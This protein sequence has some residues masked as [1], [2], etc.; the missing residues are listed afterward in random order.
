[1]LGTDTLWAKPNP[2]YDTALAALGA[3]PSHTSAVG[4][5]HD[6]AARSPPV[7]AFQLTTDPDHIYLGHMPGRY[8]AHVGVTYA[9]HDHP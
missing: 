5:I 4:I 9:C 7:V 2:N 1:M 6:F 8:P 3:P